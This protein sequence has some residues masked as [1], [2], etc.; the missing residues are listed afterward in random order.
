VSTRTLEEQAQLLS[1][2][3][4]TDEQL[5]VFDFKKYVLKATVHSKQAD[6][7][8]IILKGWEV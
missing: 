8:L 5:T 2:V 1:S 4:T 6:V 3:I 7:L